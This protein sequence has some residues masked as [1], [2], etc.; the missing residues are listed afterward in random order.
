MFADPKYK[1]IPLEAATLLNEGRVIDAI[2]VV[3]E[4]E[5]LG[6]RDAKARVDAHIAGEPLL[7]AQLELRQRAARRKFFLWFFVVD[8]VIVAAVIYWLKFKGSV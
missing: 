1:P 4:A 8:V 6:L 2:K 7:R 3:R 5:G